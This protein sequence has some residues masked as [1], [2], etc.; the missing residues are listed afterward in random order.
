[1]TRVVVGA[2]TAYVIELPAWRVLT[3]QRATG[4]GTRCPGS[5]E[6]VPGPIE[7]GEAPEDAA[8]REIFEETGLRVERLY[9]VTVQPFYLHGQGTV[10]MAVV[11]A[12]IARGEV[13]LSGEHQACEWL[14]V[15]EARE[16]FSWPHARGV[17]DQ[18][19]DVLRTGDAGPL[20][21]VLRVR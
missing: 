11:F 6:G 12:A 2:V 3:L 13:V 1:V 19:R 20:E 7:P 17:I 14:P 9:N 10:Q 21:D 5:W 16:R 18:I 4:G 15:I 8:V